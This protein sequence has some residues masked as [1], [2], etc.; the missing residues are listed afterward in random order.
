MPPARKLTL[1]GT[2]KPPSTPGMTPTAERKPKITTLLVWEPT[3][4]TPL[5]AWWEKDLELKP[6]IDHISNKS[7]YLI[8]NINGGVLL[9]GIIMG[10]LPSD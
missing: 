2:S 4:N 3:T 6:T 8:H 5:R 10:G 9:V 7:S 1:F